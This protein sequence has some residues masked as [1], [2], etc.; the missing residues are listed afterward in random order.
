MTP[1]ANRLQL[2]KRSHGIDERRE[3]RKSFQI[4]YVKGQVKR[5][6][7]SHFELFPERNQNKNKQ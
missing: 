5:F 3:S 2:M 6:S 4:V 1:L 7:I